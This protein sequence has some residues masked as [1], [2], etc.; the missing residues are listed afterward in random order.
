VTRKTILLFVLVLVGAA[1]VAPASAAEPL[2]ANVVSASPNDLDEPDVPQSIVFELYKPELPSAQPT[3]GKPIGDVNDVEVVIQGQG[4]T[5]RFPTEDLGGGRYRTEIAFPEPGGWSIRVS[6]GAGSYGA[7]DEIDLGKGGICIAADC[8]GPQ[9]GNATPAQ[10]DGRSWTTVGIVIAA[11]LAAALAAAALV[12]LRAVHSRSSRP[13]ETTGRPV[14]SG[15]S[16]AGRT[17]QRNGASRPLKAS[18]RQPDPG[19]S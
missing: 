4:Q 19:I 10:S 2:R 5:R 11:V 9:P 12:R 14:L 1:L 6:Y 7:A 17:G 16:G 13:A 8:V 18:V 3:W 15:P